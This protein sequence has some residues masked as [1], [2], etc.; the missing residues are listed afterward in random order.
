[1]A[2][3][4]VPFSPEYALAAQ[5]F[6]QR[7]RERNAPTDF[8]LPEQAESVRKSSDVIRWQHYVAAEGGEVR[9]GVLEMDQPGW[10]NGRDVR[11]L[12]FQSPLSEGIAD[13]NN[14]MVGMQL[15]KFMQ[16]RSEAAFV[17]GM[18]AATN[19]LPRLLKAA[20]WSVREV[21]FLF[22]VHRAGAFLREVKPLQTTAAR[23]LAARLAAASGL[24]ALALAVKQ[25]NRIRGDVAVRVEKQW[26]AWA[27]EIWEQIKSGYVFCVRRDRAT[28]ESLYDTA[29]PRITI[30]VMSE[31]QKVLGWAVCQQTEMKDNRYF[32]NMRVTSLLDCAALKGSVPLVAAA[33]DREAGRLGADLVLVNHSLPTW[34][35]AFKSA[36]FLSR[37]SNFLLAMSK[38][39][40]A[41]I[42]ASPS[43]SAAIH[44]TRGDGDGRI[45][46]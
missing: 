8:L 18:G 7:M 45:N 23:R 21:P 40:T 37:P 4:F 3:Q 15:V 19:P 29:D 35:E 46:L 42:E 28:L 24:G 27:D 44:I 30:L 10:L 25:R 32:G 22:R 38:P 31:G 33:A 5:R 11:A 1:V 26:G 39:L 17:V 43:G 16:K 2:L 14:L 6:N 36:G 34:V 12:N 41:A 13:G 20:G 9:G